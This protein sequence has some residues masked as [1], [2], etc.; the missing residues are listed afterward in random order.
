MATEMILISLEV[1]SR[2][3]SLPQI[4]GTNTTCLKALIGNKPTTVQSLVFPCTYETTY[5][6]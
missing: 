3:Y 5:M 6:Y 1:R 2:T 4:V